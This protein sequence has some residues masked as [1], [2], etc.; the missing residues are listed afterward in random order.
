MRCCA[1]ILNLVVQDRLK[2]IAYGIEKIRDDICSWRT[3]S[4]R[5]EAFENAAN[6]LKIKYSKK[7]V[8]DCPTTWNSTHFMLSV[9]FIYKDVF[10]RVQHYEPQYNCPMNQSGSTKYPTAN[11]VL[12][13]NGWL[14]SPNIEIQAMARGNKTKHPILA[15][16]ARDIFF[17]LV[18]TVASE[19]AFSVGGRFFSPRHRRL[20]PDTLEALMCIQNWIWTHIRGQWVGRVKRKM[21]ESSPDPNQLLI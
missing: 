4:K 18:S 20:H 8:L 14:N 12:T 17:I 15:K 13:M 5:I 21:N 11:M 16:I 10:I 2:V 7:L 19:S 9:A 6:Q 1:H 3:S